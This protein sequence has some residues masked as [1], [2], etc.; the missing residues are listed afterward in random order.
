MGTALSLPR[1]ISTS[2]RSPS[3]SCSKDQSASARTYQLFARSPRPSTSTRIGANSA[4]T[5][6]RF[7]GLTDG[8]GELLS[9]DVHARCSVI[10]SAFRRSLRRQFR[11]VRPVTGW[12]DTRPRSGR[13]A[14]RTRRIWEAGAGHASC[15]AGPRAHGQAGTDVAP[16]P[17]G[18][19]RRPNV[20][21]LVNA[22]AAGPARLGRLPRPEKPLPSAE[23]RG[24]RTSPGSP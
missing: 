7:I 16:T 21:P 8:L 19:R 20:G 9:Q 5:A 11:L 14:G 10:A 18:A 23:S 22:V 2:A 13:R 3:A 1:E 17:D 12:P 4:R 6:P 24:N 15:R